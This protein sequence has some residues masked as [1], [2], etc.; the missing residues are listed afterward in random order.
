MANS[1]GPVSIHIT[2]WF[3]CYPGIACHSSRNLH[4]V[5]PLN[6]LSPG[7]PNRVTPGFLTDFRIITKAVKEDTLACADHPGTCHILV[8][9]LLQYINRSWF[10]PYRILHRH[11]F[12][13]DRRPGPCPF[14][15]VVAAFMFSFYRQDRRFR[16]KHPVL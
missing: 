15:I 7:K 14:F 10:C 3:E 9:K 13:R 11:S 8:A 4:F 16:S 1:Y 12:R 6:Q 2:G 5:G